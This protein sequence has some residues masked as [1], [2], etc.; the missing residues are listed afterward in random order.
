MVYEYVIVGCG[1]SGIMAAAMVKKKTDNFIVIEKADNIGGVWETWSKDE[2]CLQHNSCLYL[3][4]SFFYVPGELISTRYADKNFICDRLNKFIDYKD[5]RKHIIFNTCVKKFYNVIDN[6]S[7]KENVVVEYNDTVA[8]AKNVLICTGNLSVPKNK[9][10]DDRVTK[11]SDIKNYK[12]FF[13]DKKSVMVIGSGASGIEVAVHALENNLNDIVM[14]YNSH[15]GFYFNGIITEY[16]FTLL[17]LLPKHVANHFFIKLQHTIAWYYN[18]KLPEYISKGNIE[19]HVY[20][21]STHIIEAYNKGKVKFIESKDMTEDM[22]D[23]YDAVV[24]TVGFDNSLKQFDIDSKKLY[25][26]NTRHPDYNNVYFVGL[27]K[28]NTGTIAFVSYILLCTIMQTID[29]GIQNIHSNV[30]DALFTPRLYF[31]YYTDVGLDFYPFKDIMKFWFHS[32][33]IKFMSLMNKVSYNFF[34]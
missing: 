18:Y 19:D 17:H 26:L 34:C 20:P 3:L 5:I 6:S 21:F 13:K 22:F 7:D 23:E 10:N 30:D 32:I 28:P 12:D 27:A 25:N 15:L 29:K 8:I 33:L 24:E 31:D 11:Y 16:L 2:T 9:F 4:D 14:F 1:L